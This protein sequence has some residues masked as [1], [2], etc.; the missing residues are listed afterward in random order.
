MYGA[1]A[2]V[3][4]PAADAL[5]PSLLP[6]ES[7]RRG[8]ALRTGPEIAAGA[9]EV[10]AGGLDA[11]HLAADHKLC[12]ARLRLEQGWDSCRPSESRA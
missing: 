9:V 10:L 2:A 4:A 5:M 7:M 8:N 11:A 1:L 3:T 12:R 6:S